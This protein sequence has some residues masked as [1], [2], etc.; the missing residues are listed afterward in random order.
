[1]KTF[2]VDVQPHV[3]SNNIYILNT[4]NNSWVSSFNKVSQGTPT[5]RDGTP[6][7]QGDTST[8]D[9]NSST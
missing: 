7:N 4:E 8:G 3:Y 1:R 2:P 5:N 9:G 6:N